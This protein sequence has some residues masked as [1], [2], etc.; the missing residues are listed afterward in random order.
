MRRLA[1][2]GSIRLTTDGPD[3]VVSELPQPKPLGLLAYLAAYPNSGLRR[4]DELLGLLWPE[5]DSPRGRRALSQAL[6]VLRGTLGADAIATRGTEDVGV[7]PRAVWCDVAAFRDAAEG[8]RLE[9]AMSLYAG[10]LLPGFFL[11]DAPEF[12]RWVEQERS[13]LRSRAASIARTLADREEQAGHGKAAAEWARRAVALAPFDETTLRRLLDVLDRI[14]DRAG[15]IQ[16]YN[17]FAERLERE[18]SVQPSADTVSQVQ[19]IRSRVADIPRVE[20]E[21]IVGAS[22]KTTTAVDVPSVPPAPARPRRTWRSLAAAGGLT[23]AVLVAGAA[24]TRERSAHAVRGAPSDAQRERLLVADFDHAPADSSLAVA[25]AEAIRL[26]LSRA[27]RVRPASSEVVRDALRRMRRDTAT[28]VDSTLVREVALR[29]GM[30]AVLEGDV[31]RA[32][33]GFALSARLIS[34]SDGSLVEGWRE[35]ASDSTELLAAIERLSAAVKRRV[36]E[37]LET[38]KSGIRPLHVTTTSLDALQKHAVGTRAFHDGDYARGASLL[39]EAVRLDSTF[40]DAW[41]ELSVVL[42][43]MGIRPAR[44]IEAIVRAYNLRAQFPSWER[45]EIEGFYASK[46]QGDPLAAI[47]AFRNHAELEPRDAFWASMGTLL[48]QTRQYAEAEGTMVHAAEVSPTPI[49]YANLAIARFL[50]S[51]DS[52]AEAAIT[53]GLAQYPAH[54]ALNSLRVELALS[55]NEPE[56]ADSLIHAFVPRGADRF[57]LLYQGSVD[58]IHGRLAEALDHLRALVEARE[59]QG[60]LAEAINAATF[61]A[62][63]RLDVGHDTTGA[64]QT[65]ERILA[66]H[67]LAALDV[68]ERPYVQLAHFFVEAHKLDRAK[69]LI[70]E[71]E[72][73]VPNEYRAQSH[74]LLALT[75]ASIKIDE[76][77]VDEALVDLRGLDR[78]PPWASLLHEMGRAYERAGMRDSALATYRRYLERRYLLRMEDD[79]IYAGDVVSRAVQLGLR[80]QLG[81]PARR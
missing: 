42:G 79:A 28:R 74:R 37:S 77:N 33:R 23:I 57:P 3:H 80:A 22:S 19:S 60:L 62:L 49:T 11:S 76:G 15:A 51:K 5:L 16:A 38:V 31:V 41:L 46:V 54:P 25:V 12:E 55:R 53:E 30:K 17:E 56:R 65:V 24:L 34:A 29:E 67:P 2:F 7:D 58:A 47:T 32:G 1:L 8:G 4:R 72:S 70:T 64:L 81:Q 40:A 26:D 27:S 50:L 66:R 45:Y 69:T 6:F 71:Y 68:R 59:N 10:D 36:G 73:T 78:G 43:Q 52:A 44:Q 14:G 21:P 63:L 9:E 75:R 35:T 39:E 61:E 13:E 18:L 48:I 20:R